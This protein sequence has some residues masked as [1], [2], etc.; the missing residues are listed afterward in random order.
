[1]TTA[2]STRPPVRHRAAGI[3]LNPYQLTWWRERN[4]WSRQDLVDRLA[5]LYADGHPDALPFRHRPGSEPAGGHR[6]VPG[7][8]RAR[9][10]CTRCGAP[11]AGGLTRDAIAKHEAG[12]RKPKPAT[13]RAIIAA[14]SCY[15]EPLRPGD[16]LPGA[17]ERE[18][19]PAALAR[20][21]RLERNQAMRG[22]AVAIGR[23]ELAWS[24]RGRARYLKELERLYAEYED[25]QAARSG[26]VLAS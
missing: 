16:L 19:S 20:D 9:G 13:L 25:H 10:T 26:S 21:A 1:M 3:T 12:E 2:T 17:P 7:T 4:S 23:P 18:R 5:Q 22:L 15:G 24:P 8:G 6:P 11:V 14:L